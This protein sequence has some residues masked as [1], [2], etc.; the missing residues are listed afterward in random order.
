MRDRALQAPRTAELLCRT[1]RRQAGVPLTDRTAA[2]TAACRPAPA[3][4]ISFEPAPVSAT[5]RPRRTHSGG[6]RVK[7]T[8]FLLA[9]VVPALAGCA[10]AAG[11]APATTVVI[12]QPV[13]RADSAA[14][15]PSKDEVTR[16]AVN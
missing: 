1:L 13:P 12:E 10:R 15:A 6:S 3:G 8:P 11:P 5:K 9:L 7:V 16:Q 4:G 14:D 2:S